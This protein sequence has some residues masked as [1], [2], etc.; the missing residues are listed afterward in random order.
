MKTRPTYTRDEVYEATLEYFKNDV[1][2]TNVWMNKY[3][4]KDELGNLYEKTPADMHRRL[5]KELARIELKYPNP[6]SEDEIF[7]L[8]K[9][10]KY[11]VPQ[12]SP[13]SGIG[14]DFQVVSLSNC[15]YLGNNYDSYGAIIKLDQE[16][17]QLCKR[18][19]GVGT[20]LSA[21]RPK[22]APV[23]NS[24]MTSTGVVPFM[25][26]YS[27]SIREV[28][29]SGRRGAALLS[30]SI[31]HPDAEDF[32]DAKLEQGKVTGAN[33]SVKI[34]DDFM[35]SVINNKPFTQQF[36]ID[37]NNPIIKREIDANKLWNKIIKNAYN[38]AEPGI[39]F[40]SNVIKEA[41][42]DCYS[43][44]GFATKGV[45]PCAELTLSESDSCR[46]L[47]INLY[48][49]V[50]NPFTKEASFN[51]DKFNKHCIIGQRFMDDIVDLEIEKLHKIIEKIESDPEPEFIKAVEI[52]LWK[53]IL[54]KAVRGRRC[55]FGV[56]AE[57]DMIAAMGLRYGT[58][59]ATDFA[60]D[61]HKHMAISTYMSSSIMAKERGTFPIYDFDREK[62][63]IFLNRLFDASPELYKMIKANG[64]RNIG[65]NTIAPAGSVSILTQ[66][67]S[68][69]E[70]VFLIYYKR[71][72]K[73]NPSD[74]NARIDYKDDMGDCWEEYNVFHPKF[75]KWL[76]VN[77]YN[78][79]DVKTY[80][81]EQLNEVIKLSP[82]Y[83]ATSADVDWEEKVN[84]QGKIQ[85]FVDHSISNTINLPKD[86]TVELV[87]KLYKTAYHAGCKGVTIYREGSLDA[88]LSSN[89][90]K[91]DK[92]DIEKLLK[93]NN[94]PKRP[95][96]LECD[97]IRFT[98]KG[99]KWI[100]F[101]SFYEGQLYEIFTGILES[102]PVPPKVEKGQ[103]IKVKDG[104]VK[105]YNFIYKDRDGFNVT[106]EGISRVFNEA[107]WDYAKLISALLRHNV[108]LP[109]VINILDSLRMDGDLLGTWKAGIRRIL[110]S[111][112][113]E[114]H[115]MQL[116]K[117]SEDIKDFDK[118]TGMAKCPKCG[119][120]TY[121]VTGGCPQ[122]VNDTCGYGK[123]SN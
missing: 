110:K 101:V 10:F 62:D 103:I 67:S 75:L 57:G 87:D 68:G 105:R 60:V 89:E 71:R 17:V 2:A 43:D 11:I 66:T 83:K 88:V 6:M 26:R 102:F 120:Y 19:G 96:I 35:D 45:N 92:K 53:E 28:A 30:I 34:E 5:S 76:K 27:N 49:Y 14:N 15:F 3:M 54:D 58:S 51:Y 41:L 109:S 91:I 69:V 84:M 8:L 94:A 25:E 80:K 113:S 21:L 116:K 78:V 72:R 40:W 74:K 119:Q 90:T 97:V 100:G 111:Y 79:D 93:E 95:D 31:K 46:L 106:M 65:C 48:S 117:E 32:I 13:M 98:N 18:R 42:P 7:D 77:N 122:C 121:Q 22:G 37:S 115:I 47:L 86:V 38:K 108:H 16:L 114:E 64:R 118:S 44:L 85:K 50:D 104:D 55:G 39:L 52:N 9:D 112:I 70:P 107:Y 1:L 24:A 12:G 81:T 82:Y 61:V 63:H 123:C 20:D 36:P 59:E 4:L 73:I 56:T 29:Q 23:K 99:E 33:I